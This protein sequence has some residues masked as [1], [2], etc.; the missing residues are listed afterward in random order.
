MLRLVDFLDGFHEKRSALGAVRVGAV[1]GAHIRAQIG[2][3]NSAQKY[4]EAEKY[5]IVGWFLW[6]MVPTDRTIVSHIFVASLNQR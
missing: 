5:G 1:L 4:E 6:W 3:H 2:A